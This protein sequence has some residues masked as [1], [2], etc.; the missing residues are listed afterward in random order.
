MMDARLVV[1]AALGLGVA[2]QAPHAHAALP[3]MRVVAASDKPLPDGS[4]GLPQWISTAIDGDTAF[5][6]IRD[7]DEVLLEEQEAM[8]PVTDIARIVY[9]VDKVPRV[10]AVDG[11]PLP[12][13]RTVIIGLG[14]FQMSA[15]RLLYTVLD[16]DGQTWL[17]THDGTQSRSALSG[18]HSELMALPFVLEGTNAAGDALLRL[19]NDALDTIGFTRVPNGEGGVGDPITI[20]DQSSAVPGAPGSSFALPDATL[21]AY[22]ADDGQVVFESA[23]YDGVTSSF[24][25]FFVRPGGSLE[26]VSAAFPGALDGTETCCDLLTADPTGNVAVVGSR[27]D[28]EYLFVGKPGEVALAL[29]IPV[30]GLPIGNA[31]QYRVMTFS[32]GASN[33]AA[34]AGGGMVFTA[35]VRATDPS[36]GVPWAVLS[37]RP[38]VGVSGLAFEGQP[39]PGGGQFGATF[40]HLAATSRGEY[41]LTSNYTVYRATVA[42]GVPKVERLAGPGDRLAAHDGTMVT[43]FQVTS[44]IDSRA[45][46]AGRVVL[47]VRHG[48]GDHWMYLVDGTPLPPSKSGGCSSFGGRPGPVALLVVGLLLGVRRRE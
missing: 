21:P 8:E 22:I 27:G 41:E 17:L 46:E 40:T 13:D 12:G 42:D 30:E 26:R 31:P 23:Y 14:E 11:L 37:Y 35:Q 45:L 5:L 1:A 19:R 44:R 15:A 34:A 48:R 47:D 9:E 29:T 3:Q 24:G 10:V 16:S 6:S 2:L 28:E 39:A 38:G 33:V 36:L 7:P 18:Q 25:V 43:A 32:V 4:K 20:V